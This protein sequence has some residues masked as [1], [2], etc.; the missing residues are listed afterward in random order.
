MDTHTESPSCTYIYRQIHTDRHPYLVIQI[1]LEWRTRDPSLRPPDT[2]HGDTGD[3]DTLSSSQSGDGAPT[4]RN[5]LWKTARLAT[6][7]QSKH[8][9]LDILKTWC[10][11]K[12]YK[13]AVYATSRKL[14]NIKSLLRHSLLGWKINREIQNCERRAVNPG[15]NQ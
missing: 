2:R 7:S 3:S 6:I 4:S 8:K 14:K 11:F 9:D 15:I 13:N 5:K 1:V 12:V 10:F